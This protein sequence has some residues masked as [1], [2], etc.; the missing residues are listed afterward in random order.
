MY[1]AFRHLRI[2]AR[3]DQCP[4]LI[5]HDEFSP[6]TVFRTPV[7]A[8][9]DGDQRANGLQIF[10]NIADVDHDIIIIERYVCLPS[11]AFGA[12]VHEPGQKYGEMRDFRSTLEQ[13]I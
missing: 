5:H 7:A 10:S 9:T 6:Q 2:G 3:A 1:D 11:Q 4:E 12:A 8:G 13:M